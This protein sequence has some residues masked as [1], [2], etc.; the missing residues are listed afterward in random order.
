MPD[1]TSSRPA[2]TGA[3]RPRVLRRVLIATACTLLAV[4]LALVGSVTALEARASRIEVTLHRSKNGEKTLLVVGIDD[5]SQAPEKSTDFGEP[6]SDPGARADV[7]LAIR[8]GPAGSRAVSI[9]RDLLLEYEPQ[10]YDRAATTWLRGPQP[11]MDGIC[12]TLG[13]PVDHVAVVNLRGFASLVDRIGGVEVELAEPLRDPW[14]HI[15]LPAGRQRLDG[16]EALGYVRSR[17]GEVLSQGQWIPDPEGAA[18]RQRRTGE[19]LRALAAQVPR[20]P[21]ALYGLA[22]DVLPEISLDRETGLGDLA[23]F[24]KL[25]PNVTVLPVAGGT[26]PED[27]V[28]WDIPETHQALGNLDMAP[29]CDPSFKAE[30]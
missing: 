13:M 20:N 19:V 6:G 3:G 9:T 15:D 18:G 29:G 27:W 1:P 26:E 25:T 4:L 28:A 14:A 8:T 5:R 17:Q 10:R 12:R 2:P 23:A 21:V 24:R 7:I 11:F 16:R 22:W 30:R